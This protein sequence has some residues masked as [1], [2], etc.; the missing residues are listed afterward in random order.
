MS[1]GKYLKI[2]EVAVRLNI[3]Y[4]QARKL[5]LYDEVI[6]YFKVGSRGI[7]V[8]EEDLEAY[9]DK[10]QKKEEKPSGSEGD[11]GREHHEPREAYRGRGVLQENPRRN[12]PLGAKQEDS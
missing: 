5:M 6:P 11:K 1:N 4:M 7:R 12:L 2:E 3:S 9:I 10:L 8:N